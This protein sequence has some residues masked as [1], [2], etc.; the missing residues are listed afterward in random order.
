[1]AAVHQVFR[2]QRQ[3][4]SGKLLEHAIG[5]VRM[6][7]Y[8]HAQVPK[9]QRPSRSPR[10]PQ[11]LL[12][13]GVEGEVLLQGVMGPDGRLSFPTL[14]VLRASHPAFVDAVLAAV[15]RLQ[16]APAR[17]AGCPVPMRLQQS[18]IFASGRSRYRDSRLHWR[19]YR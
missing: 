8:P 16:Y 2:R 18:F 7:H 5:E 19:S 10:Y 14:R 12:E 4:V 3:A 11:A 15:P 1:M 13:A 9:A 17:V 6:R